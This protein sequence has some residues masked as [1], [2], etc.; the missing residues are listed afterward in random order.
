MHN[1]KGLRSDVLKFLVNQ[2]R[3]PVLTKVFSGSG[4]L[5]KVTYFCYVPSADTK[6]E[7][8]TVWDEEGRYFVSPTGE[9]RGKPDFFILTP[10]QVRRLEAKITV[11]KAQ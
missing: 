9:R 5:R 11:F 8:A 7:D 1:A 6:P 10:T 4:E 3:I 2:G